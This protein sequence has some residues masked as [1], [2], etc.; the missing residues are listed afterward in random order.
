MLLDENKDWRDEN[1]L[2]LGG[3]PPAST[4]PGKR[5]IPQAIVQYLSERPYTKIIH[6]HFDNDVPGIEA[7]DSIATALYGR[8][9]VHISP[10]ETG[11]DMNECLLAKRKLYPPEKVS[12]NEAGLIRSSKRT[13]HQKERARHEEA[14]DITWTFAR[15]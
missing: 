2:S 6:L 11:K 4:N 7:A 12:R 1:L 8:C 3:I 10:P 9:E 15:R 13:R 14:P 5:S